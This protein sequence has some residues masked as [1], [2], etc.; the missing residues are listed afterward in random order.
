M[1]AY[2]SEFNPPKNAGVDDVTG[3]PLIRRSDDN[4]EALKKRLVTYHEQT[5]P[6]L[7]YYG[8][9]G[10][11]KRVDAALSPSTVWSNIASIFDSCGRK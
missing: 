3:E 7:D 10:I 2:H 4:V 9:L 8:K 6:V 11:H 1:P 5:T